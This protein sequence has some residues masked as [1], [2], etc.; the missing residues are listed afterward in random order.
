[1][2]AYTL[3]GRP[4]ILVVDDNFDHLEVMDARLSANGY[5]V[6]TASSGPEALKLVE[7]TPP[8]LVLLDV[9]MP[10]MDGL[11]TL[12]GL[13]ARQQSP[14]IPIALVSAKSDLRDVAEGL[15]A[16]ADDYLTKP[17]DPIELL[18]RVKSLLRLKALQEAVAEDAANRERLRILSDM[19]D[20]IGSSITVM[21]TMLA[22]DHPDLSALRRR[23]WS[24]L[25]EIRLIVDS[26]LPGVQSLADGLANCRHRIGPALQQA[27]IQARWKIGEGFEEEH[28]A[29][30]DILQIEMIVAEAMSNVIYHA[31]A[32]IVDVVCYRIDLGIKVSIQDDGRGFDPLAVKGRGLENIHRRAASISRVCI[33]S[34]LSSPG[35]GTRIELSIG[36]SR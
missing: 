17:V 33:A 27:N 32:R 7:T 21:L 6:L 20:S 34:I 26:S 22:S 25:T 28:L 14:Y 24:A 35:S 1:M 5:M 3:T 13:R 31:H 9:M 4:I 8:D 36:P 16:G 18:A 19:H 2:D 30:S 23:M 15:E 10:I 11:S 12:R 29:T